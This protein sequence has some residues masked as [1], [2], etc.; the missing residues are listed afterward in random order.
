ML[1]SSFAAIG[2]GH[3]DADPLLTPPGPGDDT[4]TNLEGLREPWDAY[5]V[6]IR[7]ARA[8]TLAERRAGELVAGTR[9]TLASVCPVQTYGPLLSAHGG[10]ASMILLR[11]LLSGGPAVPNFPC[12]CVDVRDVARLHVHAATCPEAAGQ[13][14][15]ACAQDEHDPAAP[16]PMMPEVSQFLAAT[17]GPR[18]FSP[19]TR[20]LP[21][22]V[23]RCLARLDPSLRLLLRCIDQQHY[24]DARNATAALGGKW[25]PWKTSLVDMAESMLAL[26]KLVPPP[27]PAPSR[28]HASTSA[29]SQPPEGKALLSEVE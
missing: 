3:G 28:S 22:C 20:T 4:W 27:P 5:P 1:T 26:G 19:P 6:D 24:F 2:F 9:T 7:Y 12:A 8:K 21:T 11:S 23:L 15:L 17:F 29:P 10:D 14:F 16:A 13:R 18:G 25:I